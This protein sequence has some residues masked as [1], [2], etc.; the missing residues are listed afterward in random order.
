M[1]VFVLLVP[2][3]SSISPHLPFYMHAQVL[4]MYSNFRL[5]ISLLFLPILYI[6]SQYLS[7]MY[8][9]SKP[10]LLPSYLLGMFHSVVHSFFLFIMFPFHQEESFICVCSGAHHLLLNHYE[11]MNAGHKKWTALYK[12]SP[13]Y[14]DDRYTI[15]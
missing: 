4:N 10:T 3:S 5:S 12:T 6:I 1:Y 7:D 14:N 9:V 15:Q 8:F 13:A 2:L 11:M